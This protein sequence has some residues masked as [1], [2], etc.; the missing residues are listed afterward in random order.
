MFQDLLPAL[1]A[2]AGRCCRLLL[3]GKRNV[4]LRRDYIVYTLLWMALDC[5]ACVQWLEQHRQYP[6]RRNAKMTTL[7]RCLSFALTALTWPMVVTAATV[8]DEAT[9][10][11]LFDDPNAATPISFDL[12]TNTVI[13][14]VSTGTD[15]RDLITFTI[16]PG[17]T[18]NELLLMDYDDLDTASANDGNRGFHA[19]NAGATSYIPDA[20]TAGNFLGGAHLDPLTPG[21]DVLPI[22][23][24]APQAGIGFTIPLGAGEYSY[25]IQQTGPQNTGYQLA[26]NV[27]PLPAAAPLF[28]SAIGLMSLLGWRRRCV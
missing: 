6:V 1:E 24:A 22:L 28:A 13:G 20:S 17:Q 14:S 9:D 10:G 18:L 23:A 21:T 25:V 11:D 16:Q 7:K 27:V 2:V 5:G 19:I 3:L 4:I 12:G 8:W 26:F 15:T